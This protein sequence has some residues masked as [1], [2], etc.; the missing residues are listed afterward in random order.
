MGLRCRVASPVFLALASA[1]TPSAVPVSP[2]LRMGRA[3]RA[4]ELRA[5]LLLVASICTPRPASADDT[6]PVALSLDV[7]FGVG[8]SSSVQ[9]ATT[10]ASA[11]VLHVGLSGLARWHFL[12]AGL[13][14]GVTGQSWRTGGEYLG[15]RGGLALGNDALR[16]E[17]LGDV[18]Q[19]RV[20]GYGTSFA[21][22]SH[23]RTQEENSSVMPCVGGRI[24]VL[25]HA[26]SPGRQFF[27]IWLG[28]RQDLEHHDVRWSDGTPAY[29]IGGRE[30]TGGLLVGATL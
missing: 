12:E 16:V 11:P 5:L 9:P 20:D 2:A 26:L 7:S 29:R 3:M 8:E 23:D 13:V 21:F 14:A 18:G 17:L 1:R 19:H 27:G 10:S 28:A 22:D 30:I 24:S 6:S 15:V 25:T 4:L